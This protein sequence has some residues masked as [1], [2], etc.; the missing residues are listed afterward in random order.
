VLDAPV[1][2]RL[3]QG[4]APAALPARMSAVFSLCGA[5]HRITSARAVCAALGDPAPTDAVGRAAWQRQDR[6]LHLWTAREHL[7][8][9]ALDLPQRVPVDGVV[10]DAA[11]LRGHPLAQLPADAES[12][13]MAS[14]QSVADGWLPW[15]EQVVLGG[16]A[17]EWRSAWR[18]E[19][20][21]A[22]GSATSPLLDWCRHRPQPVMR[23]L[24]G[25]ATVG[26]A[27]PLPC[28]PLPPQALSPQGLQT[29]AQALEQDAAFASMPHWNG[30][31]AETG[32]WTRS[33]L[34]ENAP[35]PHNAWMRWQYRMAELVALAQPGSRPVLRSGAIALADGHGLAWTEM[36]RGLLV[37]LVRLGRRA[38]GWVVDS[39]RVLAPTEW[40]F[41][42][43][44]GLARALVPSGLPAPVVQ[45][46]VAALDPCV[47]IDLRAGHGDH[48]A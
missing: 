30:E 2:Q 28:R 10:P 6:L 32:N 19:P 15:L 47:E 9:L 36:S 11:W 40:N 29:L 23:W 13:D 44:G 48:D 17:D 41:H 39:C 16:A 1:L 24:Q 27:L 42:P 46:A 14:L 20:H 33:G 5:A 43:E 35:A 25:A 8:R 45:A 21:A 31:P 34:A 4:L 18:L 26:Q 7:H 22:Q 12:A 3:V 38:G 37:H